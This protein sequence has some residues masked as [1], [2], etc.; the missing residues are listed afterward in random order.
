MCAL[1]YYK[2]FKSYI[3]YQSSYWLHEDAFVAKGLD[4]AC[5]KPC[6]NGFST[7]SILMVKRNGE[8]LKNRDLKI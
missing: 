1:H 3:W 8:H 7:L 6:Y 5:D 2:S 4:R